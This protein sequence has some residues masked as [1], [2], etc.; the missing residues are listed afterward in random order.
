MITFNDPSLKDVNQEFSEGCTLSYP[1]QNTECRILYIG[2]T[3]TPGIYSKITTFP[4]NF[5]YLLDEGDCKRLATCC[6]P[7]QS[8]NSSYEG[9]EHQ[10]TKTRY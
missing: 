7:P 9:I 10:I 1:K 2:T 3:K 4:S 6:Y 8:A 5:H